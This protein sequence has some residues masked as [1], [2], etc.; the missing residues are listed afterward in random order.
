MKLIFPW[1]QHAFPLVWQETF[2]NNH[3]LHL[4]VGFG[5]GRFTLRRALEEPQ[6]NFVALEISTTSISRLLHKLRKANLTNVRVLKL[7]AQFAVK[8]LFATSALESI[9]VNFPDPWPKDKHVDHRLLQRSFY[10]MAANRLRVGGTIRLAT[11]HPQYLSFAKE[12][13]L[14][15]SVFTLRDEPAP[16]A[17]FATKYAL[18]WK[19]QG[20]PLHYQ[21]FVSQGSDA[22]PTT[23][24]PLHVLE[25]SSMPHALLTG[26]LPK[27]ATF[28]KQVLPYENGYVIVHELLQSLGTDEDED[29]T[30]ITN[31]EKTG[32]KET[33]TKERWLF[34][35]TIDEPDIKQQVLIVA[36]RRQD[37]EF[38]VRFE[39][40]GDPVLTG[41]ARGAVH[42]VTEWLLSTGSLHLKARNY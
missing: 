11:D 31:A 15:S 30:N 19:A 18:K 8:H 29:T 6:H 27:H 3:P 2:G 34:R 7:G 10:H 17:V 40:F 1:R 26:E 22:P 21:V 35:A 14:A 25:R 41:A 12:E 24:Q 39:P 16:E 28:S 20:K 32:T 38:I 23:I 9:T 33:S 13:A 42:A 37:D 36:K 5:D 4:E